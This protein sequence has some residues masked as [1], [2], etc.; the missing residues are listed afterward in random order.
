[1]DENIGNI[2][3]L[4]AARALCTFEFARSLVSRKV[5][6]NYRFFKAKIGNFSALVA[7]RSCVRSSVSRKLDIFNILTL[8]LSGPVGSK[9][10]P[11][12]APPLRR[13]LRRLRRR[14]APAQTPGRWRTGRSSW[15]LKRKNN[16][17]KKWGI[18]QFQEIYQLKS[19][20]LGKNVVFSQIGRNSR[21]LGGKDGFFG[22]VRTYLGG[23]SRRPFEM[24]GHSYS[25]S[26]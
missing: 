2:P 10:R 25:P 8:L 23:C 9:T 5:H 12:V 11:W 24:K 13:R 18:G 6:K 15:Y 16:L 4:V 26:L 3:A 19:L 14:S 1:M 21:F 17:I 7:A 20:F 22:R